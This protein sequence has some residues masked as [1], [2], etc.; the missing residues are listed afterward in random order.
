MKDYIEIDEKRY[1]VHI[2]WNAVAMYLKEKGIEDLT[3]FGDIY[4]MSA[5]DI[6]I[7]MYWAMFYG[8]EVEGREL[9]IK[10]SYELGMIIGHV[11][12]MEFVGIFAKQMKSQL[13]PSEETQTSTQEGGEVKKKKFSFLK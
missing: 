6:L 3:K 11:K 8:E 7:L 4:S 9:P 1:R 5:E 13:P 10:S 2:C 12:I